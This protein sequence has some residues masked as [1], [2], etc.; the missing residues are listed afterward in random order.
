MLGKNKQEI[1][2]QKSKIES[3][4]PENWIV[5]LKIKY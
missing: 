5:I 2:Q 1:M 3:I 4:K